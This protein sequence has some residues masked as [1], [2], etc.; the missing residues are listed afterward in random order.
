MFPYFRRSEHFH[1]ANGNATQH[2]FDGPIFTAPIDRE[3]PLRLPVRKAFL[4][5]GFNNNADADDGYPIGIAAWIENW[6]NAVRQPAGVAYDLS[7]VQVM[8]GCQAHRV[9][10]SDTTEGKTATGVELIDGRQFRATK[11]VIISCG[12]LRTPQVLIL[13]GIGPTDVTSSLKITQHVNSPSVGQHLHDHCSLVQFWKLKNP[14]L[15]IA[16]GAPDFFSNYPKFLEGMPVNWIITGTV[17]TAELQ[18]GLL[19][20][21]ESIDGENQHP[22]IKVPQAHTEFTVACSLLG[23]PRPGYELSTDGTHISSGVVNLLPI[24]RGTVKL[25]AS[26]PQDDPL[27]DPNHFATNTDKC[28]IRAG[29]RRMMQVMETPAM[30]NFIDGEA[31]PAGGVPLTSTSS[32]EEIDDR[33]RQ[34]ANTWY[35]PA[36]MAAMGKVVDSELRVMVF[37]GCVLL[38]QVLCLL[39]F[40]LISKHVFTL[41]RNKLQ[42]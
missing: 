9:F 10:L 11:E 23:M 7:S 8:A 38:M 31:V 33:V 6:H 25:A 30:K 17:P 41:W 36:G 22:Q 28:I 21:V 42:I 34:F 3:H 19:I 2:G 18:T 37:K 29:V 12:A 15:G 27:I 32:D 1:D 26:N 13:S 20:D 4:D 39:P 35:H 5:V 16:M 40:L 14:E 24:S